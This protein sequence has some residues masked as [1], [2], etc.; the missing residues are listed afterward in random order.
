MGDSNDKADLIKTTSQI[1]VINMLENYSHMYSSH[2]KI[3]KYV[4]FKSIHCAI[5]LNV[6]SSL[7]VFNKFDSLFI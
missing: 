6:T 1:I 2:H 3:I 5:N 7:K 4:G